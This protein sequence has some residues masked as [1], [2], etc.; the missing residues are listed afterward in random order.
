VA[1]FG[2]FRKSILEKEYSV[3]NSLFFDPKKKKTKS[4]KKAPQL[5]TI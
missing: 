3:T 2:H 5:P 4:P 1:N